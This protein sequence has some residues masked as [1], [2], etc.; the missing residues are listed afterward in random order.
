[1]YLT[2]FILNTP[3]LNS[4]EISKGQFAVNIVAQYSYIKWKCIDCETIAWQVV[5][6]ETAQWH[7][8]LNYL[9]LTDFWWRLKSSV[10]TPILLEQRDRDWS[11]LNHLALLRFLRQSS[12]D[13]ETDRA[14]PALFYIHWKWE[15]RTNLSIRIFSVYSGNVRKS[16]RR[17]TEARIII[18]FLP[19]HLWP[20]DLSTRPDVGWSHKTG[21][22]A[23]SKKTSL[24]STEWGDTIAG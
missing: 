22:I 4:M 5:P 7:L 21:R 8:K 24:H 23:A 12:E 9:H 17:E 11:L 20:I 6:M 14:Y 16:G 18:L 3:V 2:Q 19:G 13:W 15:T 10:S 1:M